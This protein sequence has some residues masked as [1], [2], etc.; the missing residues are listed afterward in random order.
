MVGTEDDD[1]DAATGYPLLIYN[2]PFARDE[3][4]EPIGLGNRQKLAIFERTLLRDNLGAF[5]TQI[6]AQHAPHPFLGQR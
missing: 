6:V 5:L 1:G 3:H 2:I 4:V